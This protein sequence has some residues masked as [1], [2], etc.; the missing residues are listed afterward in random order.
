MTQD[1]PLTPLAIHES[2]AFDAEQLSRLLA[3]TAPALPVRLQRWHAVTCDG[4]AAPCGTVGEL[5]AELKPAKGV[6]AWV[7]DTGREWVGYEIR[8]LS[9]Q[10]VAEPAAR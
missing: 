4:P 8:V 3:A 1:R 7:D 10:C 5:L 6:I 2:A 9:Y